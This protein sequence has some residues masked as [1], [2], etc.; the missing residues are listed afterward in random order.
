M[1]R[2]ISMFICRD[3]IANPLILFILVSHI[4]LIW[5]ADDVISSK[6][7]KT[8]WAPR[9]VTSRIPISLASLLAAPTLSKHLVLSWLTFRKPI[10]QTL[11]S[12]LNIIS[13][14][15]LLHLVTNRPILGLDV[16]DRLRSLLLLFF[17]LLIIPWT[18]KV[19]KIY[20][21]PVTLKNPLLLG[22]VLRVVVDR[23]L[24]CLMLQD[25]KTRSRIGFQLYDR[26]GP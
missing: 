15:P 16:P 10:C 12:R 6:K 17:L 4:T 9:F 14:P 21:L 19:I 23:L 3:S 5:H 18:Q 22:L 20:P 25:Q 2:A 26:P 24:Q 11:I 1:L 7:H 8:Y 13:F